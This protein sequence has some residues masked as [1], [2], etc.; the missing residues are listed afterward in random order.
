MAN[1]QVHQVNVSLGGVPKLPVL[2]GAVTANGVAGDRQA[3]PGIHGGPY[4]ALCLF[5]LE[6]IET[7]RA[8]GHPI[9][10]GT[11][12]ENVTTEGLDWSEVKPGARLRLGAEVLVQVTSFTDPCQTIVGSFSDGNF[13]AIN[14][15]VAP[16]KSRVYAQVLQEGTLRP[17]DPIIL[18]PVP[19]PSTNPADAA[20]RGVGQISLSVADL[21]QAVRFYRDGLGI[22]VLREVEEAGLAILDLGGVRL[23]LDSAAHGGRQ[24]PSTSVV[25]LSVADID[26]SYRAIRERGIHFTAAPM[27]Q[28]SN[29]GM[30]GWMAFFHDPDGNQLAL[31]SEV[32]RSG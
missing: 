12:G 11:V 13:N 9:A 4:R 15:R 28:Y 30:E 26:S 6:L 17:G 5:P 7:L 10:P 3:T 1:P 2:E 29:D 21:Q 14:E 18:E 22:T 25:Y 16:G 24:S 32:A 31:F 8:E 19:A 20:I 27:L 23:M